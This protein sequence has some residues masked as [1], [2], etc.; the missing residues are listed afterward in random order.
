MYRWLARMLIRRSLRFHQ[1]RDVDGLL[2]SYADDVHFFFPGRNSWAGEYVGKQQVRPWLER[3]HRVGLNLRVHDIL[4]DG[5]PWNTRVCLQFTDDAK[6]ADGRIVYENRG[7]I[8]ARAAW[9]KI[10]HY[11]V[12]ED[13]EKVAD[14]DR[15]LAQNEAVSS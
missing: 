3:F 2:S 12:F 4:V 13:T 15:Y 6:D 1:S 10:R 11:E 14:L 9:G 8:Y 5:T 7:V